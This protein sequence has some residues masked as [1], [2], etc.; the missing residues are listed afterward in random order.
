V[1]FF[2]AYIAPPIDAIGWWSTIIVETH[3][4]WKTEKQ[5]FHSSN[6]FSPVLFLCLHSFE[7]LLIFSPFQ[8]SG[9]DG[10]KPNMNEQLTSAH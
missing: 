7:F 10:P 1:P 6:F 3:R 2:F 9:A 8:G 4:Y 5:R